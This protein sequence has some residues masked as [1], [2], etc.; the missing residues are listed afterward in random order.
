[1][2]TLRFLALDLLTELGALLMDVLDVG[3]RDRAVIRRAL[4]RTQ[5]Q[6]AHLGHEQELARRFGA[7]LH[8]VGLVL[9]RRGIQPDPKRMTRELGQRDP[10]Q[11]GLHE[12]QEADP[13][14]QPVLREPSSEISPDADNEN[15]AHAIAAQRNADELM[16]IIAGE[17]RPTALRGATRGTRG[18]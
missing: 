2:G 4:S 9:A 16:A 11:G 12:R 14:A 5:E 6:R 13:V 15:A 1:E 8:R 17:E 3:R 10:E 18:S 7:A